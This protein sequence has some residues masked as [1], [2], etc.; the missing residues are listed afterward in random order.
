MKNVL[1]IAAGAR[2]TIFPPNGLMH[3]A[4]VLKGKYNTVIKDYS[5][6]EIDEN[7]IRRDIEKINPFVVGISVLTG[8]PI[9]RAIEVSRIAKQMNKIVIWGGPHPT[10]LPLQTLENEYVDAVVIGEGE[11]TFLNLLKYFEG[12]KTKL[13]G[14]GIKT[15]KGI[16]IM[17]PSKKLIDL[18]KMPLPSWQL[19][20]NI[21][22]YFPEKRHNLL[23]VS[24]TRGCAFNCGFCHNSNENVRRYLGCYRIASPER[25]IQE[26]KLVQSLVKNKID[27]LD[28]GED[29]HLVN[30]DYAKKFCRTINES[31]LKIKWYTAARYQTLDKKIIDMIAKSGCVRILLGVESGSQR[32]QKMNNK[33]V[34]LNKA[35][36]IARYLRKK[37]IFVTNAYIFGHPTETAEELNQ[38][39][40]FIK[41]IPADE[42]LIQL[43]R[44]MPGTPYF[45]LCIDNK[46]IK[47]PEKLEDWSGFGVLGHDVNV[48]EIPDK[49]LF[50]SFYK[51][52]AIEQTKYWFNQQRFFLRNSMTKNFLVNFVNNRF[53]FK[54][55]E[56]LA[57]KK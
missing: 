32:I 10:V 38:T 42:N 46:K 35:I 39:I 36:E 8:P 17:P 11:E 15:K 43:Y 20:K 31:G 49:I 25:A 40:K 4:S 41:N 9:P 27:I 14:F 54:L 51:I 1:L 45:K 44:P 52:N 33:L 53:T 30:E 29:L 34:D 50:S 57:S 55:K 5:G 12:K 6:E 28:V 22:K 7:K 23:P 47:M 56:Y 48:S 18:D 21:N 24:T 13:E 3:L 19:L 26:Y 16:K 2:Y 37:K